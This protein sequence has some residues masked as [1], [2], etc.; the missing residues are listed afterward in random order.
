MQLK[1]PRGRGLSVRQFPQHER[2][3][4]PVADVLNFFGRIDPRDNLKLFGLAAFL[5][6][7]REPLV[8]RE[9]GSQSAD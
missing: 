9:P 5:G 4:S 7:H 1:G 2:Q 6:S 8:T 3:N